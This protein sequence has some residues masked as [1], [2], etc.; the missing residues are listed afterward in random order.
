MLCEISSRVPAAAAAA[1]R[2]R[3]PSARRRFVGSSHSAY[4][5]GLSGAA[6][7][8]R[9]HIGFG[10]TAVLAGGGDLLRRKAALGGELARSRARPLKC[11]RRNRLR[12]WRGCSRCGRGGLRRGL[13]RRR[14]SRSGFARA[15]DGAEHAADVDIGA[16]GNANLGQ[17]AGG[18][19]VHLQ[20]HLV[21]LEL[22]HGIIDRHRL[23]KL[24]EPLRDRGLGHGF[25]Q[26]GNFDLGR[27]AS[28]RIMG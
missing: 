15:V 14:W 2:F 28:P 12:L 27:H 21:G 26:R 7:H 25:A 3:V 17:H 24:L 9:H 1:A 10:D 20:R 4:R 11:G 23:A 13:G 22:D 18:R 16:L 6:L 5:R 8:S 19:S